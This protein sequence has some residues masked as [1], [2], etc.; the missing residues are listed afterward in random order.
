MYKIKISEGEK[1]RH[2]VGIDIGTKTG[3]SVY[4]YAADGLVLCVT[5][6]IDDAKALVKDI[7]DKNSTLLVRLENVKGW[8]P[9][10][11][12]PR[13]YTRLA[14]A[15]SIKRDQSIWE[16]FL[17]KHNIPYE[18]IGLTDCVKKVS[19]E[20]FKQITGWEGRTSEHSRDAGLMCYRVTRYLPELE[21]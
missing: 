4:D 2:I 1:Y 8:K 14:G 12:T 21:K 20:T 6:D 18:L 15:G 19:A 5:V 10:K 9:F 17:K 11:G 16:T 13:D 3:V 7:A